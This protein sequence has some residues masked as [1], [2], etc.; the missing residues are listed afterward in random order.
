MAG[1]QRLTIRLLPDGP[2]REGSEAAWTGRL[3]DIDFAGDPQS[4]ALAPGALVEIQSE[5]R[6]YLGVVQ[7]GTESRLAVLV[8]HSLERKHVDDM[9]ETW[10]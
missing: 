10:G 9:Q 7:Y 6:L 8:E 2:M 4:P 1:N 5:T 3:L